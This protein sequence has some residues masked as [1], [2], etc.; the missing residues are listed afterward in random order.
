VAEVRELRQMREENARSETPRGTETDD[1][2]NGRADL[3]GISKGFGCGGVQPAVL[4]AV[5]RGGVRA[6]PRIDT[7][8]VTVRRLGCW[9]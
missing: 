8:D 3:L 6:A 2:V 1:E 9:P 4:A 7:L 5:A